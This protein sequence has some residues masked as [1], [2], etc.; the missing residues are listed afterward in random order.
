LSERPR[1]CESCD[2]DVAAVC[3]CASAATDKFSGWARFNCFVVLSSDEADANPRALV[4]SDGYVPLFSAGGRSASVVLESGQLFP[5]H[6]SL[7]GNNA[8][9][10]CHIQGPSNLQAIHS[11]HMSNP[12]SIINIGLSI[13]SPGHM[14]PISNF[15]EAKDEKRRQKYADNHQIRLINSTSQI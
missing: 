10:S 4:E 1:G 9:E 7:A 6:A 3:S 15:N 8:Y 13:C 5:A 12:P 2:R 11:F 14:S